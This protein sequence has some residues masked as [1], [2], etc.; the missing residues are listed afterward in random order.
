MHWSIMGY[1]QISHATTYQYTGASE[2]SVCL[3]V[4]LLIMEILTRWI[5]LFYLFAMLMFTCML[6]TWC[7]YIVLYFM[8]TIACN[9]CLKP[10]IIYVVYNKYKKCYRIRIPSFNS[11]YVKKNILTCIIKRYII[12]MVHRVTCIDP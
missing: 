4:R 5:G 2:R 10:P 9:T 6:N 12:W 1:P 7:A 3:R 11:F 8:H